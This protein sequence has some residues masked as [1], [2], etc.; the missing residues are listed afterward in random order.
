MPTMDTTEKD[1]KTGTSPALEL[2][3]AALI[4]WVS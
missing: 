2:S 4:R 3:D 1:T